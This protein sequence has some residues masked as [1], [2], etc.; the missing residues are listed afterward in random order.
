MITCVYQPPISMGKSCL[1]K[2]NK[3]TRKVLVSRYVESKGGK[4]KVE[5]VP[6]SKQ[7]LEVIRTKLITK[8]MVDDDENWS[9]PEKPVKV[10]LVNFCFSLLYNA[11]AFY[12]NIN[13]Q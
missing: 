4:V 10:F 12:C 8:D 1:L 7:K 6:E 3:E 9:S 11:K 13:Q 5:I 2:V